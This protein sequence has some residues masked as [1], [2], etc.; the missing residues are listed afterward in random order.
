MQR[1]HLVLTL[2]SALL[3]ACGGAPAD[4]GPKAD[5][6]GD[7]K[8]D[9]K[10]DAKTDTKADATVGADADAKAEADTKAD[11]KADADAKTV[12]PVATTPP[13]TDDPAADSGTPEDTAEPAADSAGDSAGDAKAPSPEDEAKAKADAIKALLD[14]VK[15]KRT[16]DK[17]ADEALAEAEAAGAEASDLAKAAMSRGDKLLGTDQERARKYY[18]WARDK[19]TKYPDPVFAL[20]KMAVLTGDTTVT[21]ELLEEVKKRKGKKL[22]K[23]V[24]YD[25]LFEVVKDD[26]K[27]QALMR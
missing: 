26:P 10:A 19:D 9:T 23:K 3:L 5:S 4:P 21:I 1:S 24:G 17:R 16:K 13:G 6:Q 12:E 22:L 18:E 14:E 7:A 20:A 2:C 15:N 25:P 8:T 27:V 11:A